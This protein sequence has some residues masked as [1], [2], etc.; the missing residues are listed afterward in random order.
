MPYQHLSIEERERIQRCL[1]ERKSIRDI[2]KELDRSTSS[3]SR[4]IKR[5]LD[6]IGRR[7]YIPRVANQRALLKRK[8]RGRHERLKNQA[9]RD[10]VVSRLELRWSPEQIANRMRQDIGETISHEAIYQFIYYQIHREGYGYLRPGCHD[11]R[12]YLRRRKKRR[13]RK[14]CRRCQRIFK[15]RGSSINERPDVINQRA[16]LGDWE[17]DTV[18]SI[19]H[20]PGI[21]TLVE[22]KTGV[23]FITKLESKTS[24]A[25]TTAVAERMA[26]LPKEARRS[27]TRDNGPENQDWQTIEEKTGLKCYH[28]NAY[29]SWERGTNENTNGLIRDYFPKKTDF[30]IISQEEIQ[31]V[32][33]LLNSRPRKRLGWL[34]PLEVFSKELNRFNISINMPSVAL[35][36]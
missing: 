18:E 23:V 27:L 33:N 22:R 20:K 1:W 28:A 26:V 4:E 25:T 19:D 11:L 13:T 14:G 7:A 21:N 3:V 34:T 6:S 5:N 17:G 12:M 29:H 31:E 24:Q 8:S 32:E 35:A 9:V 10:Y 30:T 36:G 15:E 16:R 2:A